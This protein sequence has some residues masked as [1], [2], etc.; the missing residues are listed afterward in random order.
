M[1]LHKKAGMMLLILSLAGCVKDSPVSMNAEEAADPIRASQ[2][3]IE[4]GMAYLNQGQVARAKTKLL[5]AV[6]LAPE[7]PEAHSNLAYLWQTLG[8]DKEA[9]KSYQKAIALAEKKGAFYNNYGAFLCQRARYREA[10]EVLT[11]AMNDKT[12]ANMAEVYE[13]AGF[14]AL[15]AGQ[16]DK[17]EQYFTRAIQQNPRRVRA[18][19]ELAELSFHQQRYDQAETLLNSY[20]HYA[21]PSARSLWLT[22]RTAKAL[23]DDQSFQE[24]AIV[25]SDRFKESPEFQA[26][27]AQRQA[28]KG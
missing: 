14:C 27:L 8:E 7:L 13:N 2:L 1:K 9:E 5:H 19:L 24:N 12:Y 21:N 17:A 28:R 22:M 26:Y 3:N 20:R 23:G 6:E 18:M 10:E 15:Q 16:A 4:L 11:L 25:L